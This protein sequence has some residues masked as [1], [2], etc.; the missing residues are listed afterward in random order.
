MEEA[1]KSCETCKS[2]CVNCAANA[3]DCLSCIPGMFLNSLTDSCD[4][5]TYP[6]ATCGSSAENCLTCAPGKIL[7]GNVCADTCDG[8]FA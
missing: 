5:C 4:L 6:C 7:N 8:L 2:Q 3:F 1:D